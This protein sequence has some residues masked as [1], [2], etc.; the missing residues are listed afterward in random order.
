MIAFDDRDGPTRPDYARQCR[1]GG[2]WGREVFE[3][4]ADEDVV[5]R[6]RAERELEQVRLLDGDV[7]EPRRLDAALR[8]GDGLRRDID[9]RKRR[10]W[11]A[12]GEREGLGADAAA[13][14]QDRLLW[15]VPRVVVK[16]VDERLG[17]VGKALGLARVVA[18]DVAICH[19]RQA[20]AWGAVGT[21]TE[22]REAAGTVPQ[23]SF[24]PD[25]AV[26]EA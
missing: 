19:R 20:A 16:Q 1:Q 9:R 12:A 7:V 24:E 26:R 5:E 25:H 23:E 22:G 3:D 6:R 2:F 18:V 15:W 21:G 4:E 14:F 8:F 11:T 10:A 17:L 13:H